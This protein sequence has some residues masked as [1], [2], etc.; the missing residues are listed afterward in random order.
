M[1]TLLRLACVACA[2]A[3]SST[4][5]L[6]AQGWETVLNFQ[7]VTGPGQGAGG[8]AIA[9]DAIGNVFAGGGGKDASGVSHGLVLKTDTTQAVWY[10]SD[11]TNP[12][13]TQYNSYLWNLGYDINGNL[14]SIGQ[15]EPRSTAIRYWYV[16]KSADSGLNWSTVDVFQYAAG[17]SIDATGFAADDAGNIYVAGW[18]RDAGTKKN[19]SGNLHWL[20]KKSADAGQ[21]WALVDDVQ[22]PTANGAG[23]VPGAGVF[24]VG[25][26]RAGN[27][28]RVASAVGEGSIA[29]SFVHQALHE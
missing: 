20:V 10:F 5:P 24:A 7:L 17:Q 15:L 25:D 3:I 29:V 2:A 21:T 23:F 14:Y 26:V 13:A 9:A 28:K 8:N 12:S 19:P 18:S 22:G 6:F 11:D 16:R 4:A 27:I 1:K